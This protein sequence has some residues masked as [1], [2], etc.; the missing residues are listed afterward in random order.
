MSSERS[1]V[2]VIIKVRESE[3]RRKNDKSKKIM[4]DIDFFGI[5]TPS[6]RR[7]LE[8]SDALR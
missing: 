3:K 4:I 5:Q 8:M 6:S 1:S 2:S 7:L